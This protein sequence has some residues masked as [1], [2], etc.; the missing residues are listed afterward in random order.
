MNIAIDLGV[1]LQLLVVA[2]IAWILRTL[3]SIQNCLTKLNTWSKEHEKIDNERHGDNVRRLDGIWKYLN[4][5][6]TT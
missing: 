4:E 3:W 5:R 6:G 2:G 1:V